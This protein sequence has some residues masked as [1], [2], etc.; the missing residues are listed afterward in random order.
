MHSSLRQLRL[1]H[2]PD[3][4]LGGPYCRSTRHGVEKQLWR[5]LGLEVRLLCRPVHWL[6]TT[7]NELFRFLGILFKLRHKFIWQLLH[8]DGRANALESKGY[9][10]CVREPNRHWQCH[11]ENCW[12]AG[13]TVSV[14]EQCERAGEMSVKW[15]SK[16]PGRGTAASCDTLLYDTTRRQASRDSDWGDCGHLGCDAVYSGWRSTFRSNILPACSRWSDDGTSIMSTLTT[17]SD[18]RHSTVTQLVCR[19]MALYETRKLITV[20]TKVSHRTLF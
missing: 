3:R 12:H 6:V 7:P 19:F 13:R 4:R 16:G 9:S 2:P 8:H 14:S 18:S 10:F 11:C 15:G 20:F 5:L 1:G 17:T